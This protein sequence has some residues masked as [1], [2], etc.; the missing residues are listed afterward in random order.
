MSRTLAQIEKDGYDTLTEEEI[1]NINT[2]VLS[3]GNAVNN[4]WPK[5]MGE[6]SDLLLR[7]Y[8]WHLRL[9]MHPDDLVPF[10]KQGTD[11]VDRYFIKKL[12]WAAF[13]LRWQAVRRF[14]D[15]RKTIN[16]AFK[17]HWR[18]D[19]QASV[20]LMLMLSE[21]IFRELTGE[22]LFAK[23]KTPKM[24]NNTK[25]NQNKKTVPLM[26]HIIN[27]LSN[28]DVIGLRF[29]GDE[30]AKF[31]NVLSRNKIL[32]GAD[33]DFGTK[34]NAYKALSQF[35]FVVE[36]VYAALTGSKI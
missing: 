25:L 1:N 10:I 29:T 27:S 28:G 16:S 36:I 2:A 20:P 11:A 18:G 33:V 4:K 17:A 32:H 7:T 31:P 8:G 6:A 30:Y 24:A 9:W 23:K 19:Y 14:P 34:L 5:E 13:R 15:R 12:R 35:E 21:G 26:T 3:L 22:D